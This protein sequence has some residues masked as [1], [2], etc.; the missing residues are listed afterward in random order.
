MIDRAKVSIVL[1]RL[2]EEIVVN[3]RQLLEDDS[4]EELPVGVFQPHFLGYLAAFAA[5]TRLCEEYGV[6]EPEKVGFED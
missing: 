1:I 5:A 6:D 2:S 4:Y 3:L